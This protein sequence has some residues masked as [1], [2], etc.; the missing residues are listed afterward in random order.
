MN[1]LSFRPDQ[2]VLCCICVTGLVSAD[3]CYLVGGSVSE[4]SLGSRIVETAG[5]PMESLSS[6]ASSSLYLI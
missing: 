1:F 5:L 4:K 2:T 6:S 3:V